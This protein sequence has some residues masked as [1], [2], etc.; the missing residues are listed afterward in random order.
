MGVGN[1]G[2]P[3]GV[4]I[5]L[6]HDVDMCLSPALEMAQLEAAIGGEIVLFRVSQY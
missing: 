2:Q 6:R 1:D 4:A 3:G 5:L